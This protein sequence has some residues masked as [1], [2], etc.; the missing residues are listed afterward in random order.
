MP[1]QSGLSF[2]I[3]RTS[4][5]RSSIASEKTL[6]GTPNKKEDIS[7]G[8]YE[9]SIN[10]YRKS[11]S[12]AEALADSSS[13]PSKMGKAMEKVKS[14]LWEKNTTSK[15]RGSRLARDG[16]PDTQ[17]MWQALAETRL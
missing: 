14:K 9:G 6:V 2:P 8:K 5:R 7:E 17:L 13:L 10:D 11:S 4:Q 15:P 12:D 1:S 16:Y 3:A